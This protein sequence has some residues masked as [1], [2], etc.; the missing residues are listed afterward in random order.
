M[1]QHHPDFYSIDTPMPKGGIEMGARLSICRLPG[2]QLWIHAPLEITDSDERDIREVGEVAHI[3]V[4]NTFH[5]TQVGEFARRFP[6]AVVHAPAPLEAKLKHV[7]HQNLNLSQSVFEADFDALLFD[8]APLLH[9]W[10]FC[11]RASQ[12]LLLTDLCFN[13]EMPES[14]LGKVGAGVLDLGNGLSPSRLLRLDLAIGDRH[15]TRELLDTVLSW[16]FDRVSVAHGAVVESG[17]K[18]AFKTAFEWLA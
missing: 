1:I 12:T 18:D 6:D 8:T 2:E 4:P 5:F 7:P 15:K 17:G 11:H 10:V 16:D 13:I 9:E 14:P 3:I